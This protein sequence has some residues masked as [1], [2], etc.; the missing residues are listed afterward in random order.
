MSSLHQV[1]NK[2]CGVALYNTDPWTTWRTAF[3]ETIKLKYY[4][5]VVNNRETNHRLQTWLSVGDA[6]YGQYSTGGAYDAIEYYESVDGNLDDLMNSYDWEWIQTYYKA[7][8]A[9]A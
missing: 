3:R 6:E 8:Y 9:N 1:V 2:N 7:K 4:S 5:D